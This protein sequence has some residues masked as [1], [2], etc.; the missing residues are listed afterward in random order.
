MEYGEGLGCVGCWIFLFATF[1]GRCSIA[2]LA[3]GDLVVGERM[4][5]GRGEIREER[6]LM[7]WSSISCV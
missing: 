3:W 7:P 1:V 2:M 4:K 6:P 5:G